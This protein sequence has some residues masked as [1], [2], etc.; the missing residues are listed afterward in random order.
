MH[1]FL[2]GGRT[3]I[4]S[5]GN[6]LFF[7]K[8]CRD[9]DTIVLFPFAVE[10]SERE[11]LYHK[12]QERRQG[13]NPDKRLTFLSASQDPTILTQQIQE[14]DVLFFCGG[15]F[16]RG[17]LDILDSIENLRD[18]V[19]D[20]VIVGVSAGAL[21]WCSAYYSPRYERISHGNG[22]IPVKMMVHR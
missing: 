16:P 9:G 14:S 1:F 5:E 6:K 3:D 20:K 21:I 18:L 7:Q 17:H 15:P 8:T 4:K 19:Q 22:W 2:H 12:Y 13:A 10:E 11:D